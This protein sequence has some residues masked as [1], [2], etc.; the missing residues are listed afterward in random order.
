MNT[1][2]TWLPLPSVPPV[3]RPNTSRDPLSELP[4]SVL[5]TTLEEHVPPS[6][7]QGSPE[8]GHCCSYVLTPGIAQAATGVQCPH[9]MPGDNGVTG[10]GPHTPEL[11]REPASG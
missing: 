9:Q 3:P 8:V 4:F 2:P 1:F 11:N 6:E 7:R 10:T 5:G